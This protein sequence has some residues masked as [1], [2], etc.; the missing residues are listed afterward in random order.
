MQEMGARWLEW[1]SMLGEVTMTNGIGARTARSIQY[2][3]SKRP[4]WNYLLT[5]VNSARQKKKTQIVNVRNKKEQHLNLSFEDKFQNV[6]A[7]KFSA[8]LTVTSNAVLLTLRLWLWA[9]GNCPQYR[10]IGA[11]LALEAQLPAQRTQ[12]HFHK[13]YK[14]PILPC[15]PHHNHDNKCL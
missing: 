14:T 6:I 12:V 11:L 5:Y 9:K 4:P 2:T 8:R 13:P 15:F 10:I 1:W 3:S 7:S